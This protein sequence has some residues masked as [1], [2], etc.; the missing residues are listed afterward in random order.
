MVINTLHLNVQ[1]IPPIALRKR[2]VL[3][4]IRDSAGKYLLGEKKIYPVGICRMVGGGVEEHESFIEAAQR[5]LNEE[6]NISATRTELKELVQVL[7]H[8]TDQTSKTYKFTTTIYFLNLGL[9]KILPGDDLDGVLRL[10]KVEFEALIQ[11]YYHLSKEIDPQFHFS[12]YDYGQLYGP[13]HRVA[14]EES[15]RM[16][17]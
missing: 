7:A 3:F 16:T 8:I 6:L 5:E 12:W 13:I 14:L 10:T 1:E 2:H 15:E 9:R 17:F 11:R 4:M